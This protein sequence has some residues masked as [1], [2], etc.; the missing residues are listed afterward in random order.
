MLTDKKT[1]KHK[2][3]SERDESSDESDD[4]LRRVKCVRL[5]SPPRS[6]SPIRCD[7]SKTDEPTHLQSKT[8]EMSGNN[9][10]TP[11]KRLSTKG[12]VDDCDDESEEESESDDNESIDRPLTPQS[13]RSPSPPPIMSPDHDETE[14]MDLRVSP[15]RLQHPIPEYTDGPPDQKCMHTSRSPVTQHSVFIAEDSNLVPPH[16]DLHD[17]G[18]MDHT[19]AYNCDEN[20]SDIEIPGVINLAKG[21]KGKKQN[22]RNR[23]RVESGSGKSR[24]S[25]ESRYTKNLDADRD[26]GPHNSG[27][28]GGHY[29]SKHSS[30][31]VCI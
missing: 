31:L 22:C 27:A 4:E 24:V 17:D 3:S 12:S 20:I 5:D 18:V 14:A 15:K 16:I 11:A 8:L 25:Q 2:L 30:R 10:V 23:D 13:I 9:T 26:N 29:R 19:H 21:G 1:R 7:S 28:G 6:P